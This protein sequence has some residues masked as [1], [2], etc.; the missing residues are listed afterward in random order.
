[1]VEQL[2]LHNSN[3]DGIQTLHLIKF[4]S[5]S[6]LH[7]T[8][9][10][11]IPI[12][13][14]RFHPFLCRLI[15]LFCCHLYRLVHLGHRWRMKLAPTRFSLSWS[16]PAA[17]QRAKDNQAF[18]VIPSIRMVAEYFIPRLF[19]G[20]FYD[21]INSESEYNN[22]S[23]LK[24]VVSLRRVKSVYRLEKRYLITGRNKMTAIKLQKNNCLAFSLFLCHSFSIFN[25]TL[26]TSSSTKKS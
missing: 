17:S 7:S 18:I 21:V 26:A 23:K 10:E 9:L 16:S 1:M 4:P 6:D 8:N 11:F 3:I 24:Q 14:I 25:D 13:L 15:G 5:K 2:S 20:R 19:I 12:F 22:G